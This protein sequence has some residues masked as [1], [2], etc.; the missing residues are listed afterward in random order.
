MRYLTQ[1]AFVAL[2]SAIGPVS[3]AQEAEEDPLENPFWPGLSKPAQ[4]DATS[5]KI[6]DLN[7]KSRGG[8][9]A[10]EAVRSLQLIGDIFE[11][12]KDFIVEATYSSTGAARFEIYYDR[13]GYEYRTVRATDG[14][15]TWQ[16]EVLPEKKLPSSISGLESQLLDL[17]ARLPF[18]LLNHAAQK[19]V[20]VYTGKEEYLDRTAYV[21][22]GWLASGLQIDILFDEN[23]FQILNYRHIYKIGGKEVL[24]NLTP[25]KLKRLENVWWEMEYKMNRE[26]K[27]FRRTTFRKIK[28]NVEIEDSLFAQPVVKEFWL[29]GTGN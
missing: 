13:R 5:I 8:R 1:L 7:I 23:T 6:I 12:Q 24:V 26:A 17:D 27:T 2:I 9:E 4:T 18:L 14:K 20:F 22:H 16:Q 10:M 3:Q 29:R 11:G 21:L 28:A 15:L 19:D 25:S